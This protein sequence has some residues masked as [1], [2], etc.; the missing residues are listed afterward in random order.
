MGN[1]DVIPLHKI[2]DKANEW[3]KKHNI[4]YS[5][6]VD[7]GDYETAIEF[8]FL[9][10]AKITQWEVMHPP[11]SKNW[12]TNPNIFCPDIMDFDNKIII[13]Y[14]EEGQKKRSGAHLATKGHGR[15]GDLPTR[16]DSRRT[17]YYSFGKFRVL[18]FYEADLSAENWDK[19]YQFLLE[20]QSDDEQIII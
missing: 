16:K 18:R 19:L 7:D 3:C 8:F 6:T 1:I 11:R 15:E 5:F 10:D 14:E 4:R 9:G 12:D 20:C 17:D 13:E 2:Y